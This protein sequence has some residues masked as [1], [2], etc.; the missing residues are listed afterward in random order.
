MKKAFSLIELIIVVIIVGVIYTLAINSFDSL[1]KQKNKITLL[2]LKEQLQ[3]IEHEKSVSLLCLDNCSNCNIYVD[4]ELLLDE[5]NSLDNF[6]DD[7][8]V[9]YKYNFNFGAVEIEKKVYFNTQNIEENI[10]F[11]F[12]VDTKGVGDQVLIEYKNIVYDYSTYLTS[13]PTYDSIQEAV[14]AKESLAQEVKQ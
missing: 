14:D 12:S 5:S 8:I 10:C 2:N 7:S 9:V 1:K 3:N 4:G 6:I 11:S 13:T